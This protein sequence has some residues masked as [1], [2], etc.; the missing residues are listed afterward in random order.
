MLRNSPLP[1]W[2][3]LLCA[4]LLAGATAAAQGVAPLRID[5]IDPPNWYATLPKPLLLLRGEGFSGAGFTL[6]DPAIRIEHST[7]SANGHWAQ[8]WLSASPAQPETVTLQVAR[9][10]D[11]VTSAYRFDTP[12]GA[13]GG[14]AG[15]NPRDLLYLI[16]T[17]RFADGNLTNDGPEAASPADSP[18]A[19][20][21]RAK[22][23]GWHGGDLPGIT[24]HLDYLQALGV[25]AVWPTPVYQNHAA[26]AYHGYHSTDYYSVDPHYGTLTDLQALAAALHARGMKLVLDTVP[27]HVGPAH[28]WVR[29]E[30]APDWFHGTLEHH[31]RGETNFPALID[32]HAPARDTLTT[33][34]GWFVDQLPDMNTDNPAVA[35]YLRQNA[36]WWIEQTG[37]DGLR[38]D[39]FA[40]VDRPFWQAFNGELK[41]LFPRLTEVGE[42][43]D[44]RPQITSAFAEGVTR[45]GVDTG[46]YTP[47][48]FPT[49]MAAREVF[50]KGEPMSK[51]ADVLAADALYPHPERLVPFL[52]NHD[53][54][55]FAEVVPDPAVQKLAFAY[56]LTTRGTPQIYAGDEIAMP[57]GGDPDNRRDF[58]GGFPAAH[59]TT[60][61]SSDAFKAAGRTQAQEELYRWIAGLATLRRHLP[62]LACGQEQT[63]ATGPDLLAYAR[64]GVAG[65]ETT[66]GAQP[67]TG[68]SS[69]QRVLVI[70]ERHTPKPLT[71]ELDDTALAGC[72]P[73][74]PALGSMEV[75]AEGSRLQ[76]SPKSG[77]VILPCR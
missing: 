15:F 55:R 11:A 71:L 23:R 36:V 35:L 12:R 3:A 30:P 59:T 13:D 2:S 66:A 49:Y 65:C 27:N 56:L 60:E 20:A 57:G 53:T 40:Y 67:I 24:A 62:A 31:L 34:D 50:G 5:K 76:L 44:G 74:A 61:P 33:L 10:A 25:T 75:S 41:T 39:T 22:S 14:M 48:D 1:R 51:L 19:A 8:L 16:L 37:A 17:D 28:P 45:A 18:A 6:S 63:L 77:V 7:V 72:R 32:P 4:S 42:V 9:G 47:F 70:L 64:Y 52:G 29:D 38:I 58:P 68:G 43:F 69:P 21:E 54:S 26:Q 46:L 73:G